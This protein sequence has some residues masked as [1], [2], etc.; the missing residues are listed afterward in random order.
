M[1]DSQSRNGSGRV[2]AGAELLE[3]R[4]FVAPSRVAFGFSVAGL[5]PA[6]RAPRSRPASSISRFS[7]TASRCPTSSAPTTR[8]PS[9][10]GCPRRQ[11]GPCDDP[12]GHGRRRPSISALDRHIRRP[13]SSRSTSR[14]C[15]R[16][17]TICSA[18]GWPGM[19]SR[20]SISRK[21]A[22]SRSWSTA[23]HDL[24]Y[25]KADEFMEVVLGHWD[26]WADDALI[27]DK[28][29]GRFAD[30]RQGQAARL[31]RASGSVRAG[32]F[33]CRVHRRADQ[34]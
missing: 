3:L 27:V 12:D 20:R 29:S 25:D 26:S 24:R 7:T 2:P 8:P 33:R 6:H 19:S 4:R 28:E 30:R 31:T 11:D 18:G 13:I 9:R 17:W 32:H 21:R 10:S 22:T 14:A 1:T 5:L 15:S 16:P 34:C 23:E